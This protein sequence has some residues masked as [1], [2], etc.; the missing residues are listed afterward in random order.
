D[1]TGT[2]AG[3]LQQDVCAADLLLNLVRQRALVKRDFNEVLL[4]YIS[5]FVNGLGDI[6][7]LCRTDAH[8]MLAVADHHQ[9][10][11]AEAAAALDDPRYAI[12]VQRPFVELLLLRLDFRTTVTPFLDSSI[13]HT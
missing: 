8:A 4:S 6:R 1:Q 11:E 9:S 5:S 2:G 7:A 13:C 10:A 12:D 3:W